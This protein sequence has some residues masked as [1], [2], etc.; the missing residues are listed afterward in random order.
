M[1]NNLES[2]SD[3]ANIKLL[4]E[5]IQRAQPTAKN[6]EEAGLD[7]RVL[8]SIVRAFYALFS[9]E[10]AQD[11]QFSAAE[12]LLEYKPNVKTLFGSSY[13]PDSRV[14]WYAR[15]VKSLLLLLSALPDYGEQFT[16]MNQQAEEEFRE[17]MRRMQAAY[18]KQQ[19][20]QMA[21]MNPEQ[22]QMLQMMQMQQQAQAQQ[23]DYD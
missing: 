14:S 1:K 16:E 4:L 8:S 19:Q 7:F 5:S 22:L 18:K 15:Q 21:R 11:I 13:F 12:C 17:Q 9:E 2:F 20:E 6:R 10:D 23:E 3:I